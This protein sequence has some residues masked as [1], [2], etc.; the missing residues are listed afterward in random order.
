MTDYLGAR[1]SISIMEVSLIQRSVIYRE[2][3]LYPNPDLHTH[4]P[5]L[6]VHLTHF[7]VCGLCNL[8]CV[9]SGLGCLHNLIQFVWCKQASDCGDPELSNLIAI[10]PPPP[11]QPFPEKKSKLPGQQLLCCTSDQ[12]LVS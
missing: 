10:H 4:S 6:I 7:L 5:L 2:V 1:S 8:F 3:P 11:P 9:T 12:P